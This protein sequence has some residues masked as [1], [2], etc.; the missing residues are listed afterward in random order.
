TADSLE[1]VIPR[2]IARHFGLEAEILIHDR[3]IGITPNQRARFGDYTA[4][5]YCDD[6]HRKTNRMIENR[7]TRELI[8][9]LFPGHALTLDLTEQ[10]RLTAW[11]VKTC[12]ATWGRHR[13]HWGVPVAHRRH[14]IETGGPGRASAASDRDRRAVARR[15]RKRVA[16]DRRSGAPDLRSHGD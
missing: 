14:L 13:C 11:A 10:R 15:L 9:R 4:R 1:H 16:N 12:I 2:W 5:I 7:E 6:C 8:K 3:A